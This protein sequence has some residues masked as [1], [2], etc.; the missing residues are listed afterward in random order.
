LS[1]LVASFS[2]VAFISSQKTNYRRFAHR[3]GFI[4]EG[5]SASHS[6]P[7]QPNLRCGISRHT[8]NASQPETL[9]SAH[10]QYISQ[11]SISVLAQRRFLP[12]LSQSE[13]PWYLALGYGEPGSPITASS[14][15]TSRSAACVNRQQHGLPHLVTL[16][17]RTVH[18]GPAEPLFPALCCIY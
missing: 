3:F 13:H 2:A 10:F 7:G 18:S 11:A 6:T 15:V 12:A 17:V 1:N 16:V 5:R 14:V 4:I 9:N 8:C